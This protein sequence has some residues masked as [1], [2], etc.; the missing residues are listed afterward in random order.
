MLDSQTSPANDG[1]A[2]EDLGVHRDSLEEALFIRHEGRTKA[3][4]RRPGLSLRGAS[5]QRGE[6]CVSPRRV[7]AGNSNA[8]ATHGMT[9]P[10][11]APA[12]GETGAAKRRRRPWEVP[13]EGV[14]AQTHMPFALH[15]AYWHDRFGEPKSGGCVNLSVR[16]AK[17]LF[18][19]TAPHV[20]ET[21]HLTA[22]LDAELAAAEVNDGDLARLRE[23]AAQAPARHR[24]HER[25][26]LLSSL[27][28]GKNLSRLGTTPSTFSCS[29]PT[30][31]GACSS[32]T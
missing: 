31:S 26:F 23:A 25:W 17:W 21:W 6:G 5:A 2:A 24:P 4:T 32:A 28:R 22:D 11:R 14:G 13:E 20:P 8:L 27:L 3:Y 19:W 29:R 12:L 1:L 16:D 7:R 18:D 15:A 30:A 9:R 10:P